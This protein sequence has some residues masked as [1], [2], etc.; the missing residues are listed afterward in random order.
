MLWDTGPNRY[1][2]RTRRYS[3]TLRATG[4]RTSEVPQ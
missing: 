1:G 2:G 4:P 3:D